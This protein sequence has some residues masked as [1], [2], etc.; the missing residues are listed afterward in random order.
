M[1]CGGEC[2]RTPA[3][4]YIPVLF[5]R[6]V[7]VFLYSVLHDVRFCVGGRGDGGWVGGGDVFW[8]FFRGCAFV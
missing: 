3:G 4:K 5:A 6:A 2:E 8:V 1:T 7:A